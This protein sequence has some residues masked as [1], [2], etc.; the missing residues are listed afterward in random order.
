MPDPTPLGSCAGPPH[1]RPV[2]AAQPRPLAALAPSG[3]LQS[4]LLS[5]RA[6]SPPTPDPSTSAVL[7][8]CPAWPPAP[9]SLCVPFSPGPH[10]Q[11][12]APS[13]EPLEER[14]VPPA[15]VPQPRCPSRWQMCLVAG[16]GLGRL[17]AA[18]PGRGGQHR[19]TSPPPPPLSRPF[20]LSKQAAPHRAAQ[21]RALGSWA[22]WHHRL[23]SRGW[24]TFGCGPTAC[25]Q[26]PCAKPAWAA[27]REGSRDASLGASS[28]SRRVLHPILP[29]PSPCVGR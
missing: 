19:H 7:S 11:L 8:L 15:P 22:P 24:G 4:Q 28:S 29:T 21:P 6:E 3:L 23:S 14:G 12:R 25:T 16:E 5:R 9:A 10:Q 1:P 17:P 26:A 2:P 13:P 20:R 18:R 27:K